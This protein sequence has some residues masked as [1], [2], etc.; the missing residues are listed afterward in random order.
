[1]AQKAEVLATKCDNPWD[2]HDRNEELTPAGCPPTD[3]SAMAPAQRYTRAHTHPH[4]PSPIP[5]T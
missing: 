2:P 1:M 3:P 4:P 5:S